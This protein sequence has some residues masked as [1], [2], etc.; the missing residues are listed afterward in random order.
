MIPKFVVFVK[1]KGNGSVC[2]FYASYITPFVWCGAFCSECNFILCT[3]ICVFL[4]FLILHCLVRLYLNYDACF[5]L[6]NIQSFLKN[7]FIIMSI[8][9]IS[10]ILLPISTING[11]SILVLFLTIYINKHYCIDISYLT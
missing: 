2:P 6:I 1:I 3:V 5:S 7:E 8:S 10:T 9:I 4:L 11:P